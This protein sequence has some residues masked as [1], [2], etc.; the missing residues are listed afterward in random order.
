MKKQSIAVIAAALLLAAPVAVPA[1]TTFA[2]GNSQFVI[3]HNNMHPYAGPES[4]EGGWV[5]VGYH[6]APIYTTYQTSTKTKRVLQRGTS[7]RY[8]GVVTYRDGSQWYDLGGGHQWVRASDLTSGLV[9]NQKG[10]VKVK[11][12]P[13]Y[14]IAVW[15]FFDHGKVTGKLLKNGTSWKYSRYSIRDNTRWYDLGGNQWVDGRY[16][17]KLK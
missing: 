2:A 1:V 17:Q 6:G 11:Y 8:S 16:V 13:G 14:S 5:V 7:W 9:I 10:V 15:N 12:V 4:L 3:N